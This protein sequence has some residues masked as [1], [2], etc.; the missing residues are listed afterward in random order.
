MVWKS[1]KSNALHFFFFRPFNSTVRPLEKVIP[2][3]KETI[4]KHVVS[5]KKF[6]GRKHDE[7]EISRMHG[8][9]YHD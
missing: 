7:W 2:F 5:R 8:K 6:I 1:I 4:L 9:H 3:T